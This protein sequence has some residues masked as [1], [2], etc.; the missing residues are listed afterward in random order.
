M[1]IRYFNPS[2]LQR[3]FLAMLAAISLHIGSLYDWAVFSLSNVPE[4]ESFE[5]L[6]YFEQRV[7]HGHIATWF[8]EKNLP[9][10]EPVRDHPRYIALVNRIEGMLAVR[11]RKS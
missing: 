8:Q 1:T 5:S 11:A 2:L 7:A 10:W 9:W 3:L 4:P 6:E